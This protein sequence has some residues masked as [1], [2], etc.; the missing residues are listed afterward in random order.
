MT[1]FAKPRPKKRAI[2]MQATRLFSSFLTAALTCLLVLGTPNGHAEIRPDIGNGLALLDAQSNDANPFASMPTQ[3]PR[4]HAMAL[5]GESPLP[6]VPEK[7]AQ[8]FRQVDAGGSATCGILQGSRRLLCWGLNDMGQASPPIGKYR[9]IAMGEHHGCAITDKGRLRC[10]GLY[11]AYP[12][13]EQ[14]KGR[15]LSV[16]AG[17]DHTCAIRSNHTVACWGNNDNGELDAPK[18]KFRQLVARGN[19]SCGVTAKDGRL[20]CWGDKSFIGY[21]QKVQAPVKRVATGQLHACALGVDGLAKCWGN[22]NFGETQAPADQFVDIVA[23]DWHTCGLRADHTALCWGRDQYGQTQI[24][25][26]KYRMIAAGGMQTCGIL[27]GSRQMTCHGSFASNEVW[28][29]QD[30]DAQLRAS[31]AD[32]QVRPQLAFLSF[33]EGLSG[34]LVSGLVNTGKMVDQKMEKW[35]GRMVP[36][37]LGLL[38]TNMFLGWLLPKPPNYLPM[39]LNKLE[40]IQA[41]I[42][43]LQR[44]QEKLQKQLN[45]TNLTLLKSW[46][47]DR[48]DDYTAAYNLLDGQPYGETTGAHKAFAQVVNDQKEAL[49]K[50]IDGGK[51]VAAPSANLERFRSHYLAKL[52]SARTK[53]AN[54][55][56]GANGV[57]T[58]TFEACFQKGYA[59][60]KSANAG[61]A[62]QI[63]PFDDRMIYQHT[64]QILRGA[65]MMQEEMLWMEQEVEMQLAYQ[66]L[67]EPRTDGIAPVDFNPEEH[68]RGLCLRA[69]L[70]KDPANPEYNK[71]WE[72][73]AGICQENRDRIQDAYMRLVGQV[74]SAGGAY[75]DDQ[76]VLSLTSEQMGLPKVDGG[77][78][79]K[80]SNWLWVRNHVSDSGLLGKWLDYHQRD[81][82]SP[83]YWNRPQMFY[84]QYDAGLYIWNSGCLN[85][86]CTSK[87]ASYN[88]GV[89]HSNGQAWEDIKLFRI[90]R[91][92]EAEEAKRNPGKEDLLGRMSTLEDMV[93]PACKRDANGNCMTEK[94]SKGNTVNIEGPRLPLFTGI[95]RKPFWMLGKKFTYNARSRLDLPSNWVNPEETKDKFE[96]KCFVAKDINTNIDVKYDSGISDYKQYLYQGWYRPESKFGDSLWSYWGNDKAQSRLELSGMVCGMD[97]MAASLS[98]THTASDIPYVKVTDCYGSDVWSA[99]KWGDMR[100]YASFCSGYGFNYRPDLDKNYKYVSQLGWMVTK[101]RY[102]T[103]YG[104]NDYFVV[105]KYLDAYKPYTDGDLY[106]MPVVNIS[107]RKCKEK[108]VGQGERKRSRSG[109]AGQPEIPSICGA[110]LDKTIDQLIPRPEFPPVP[111]NIVRKPEY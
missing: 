95:D 5:M 40:D 4:S 78:D 39:I 34:L 54:S 57:Q 11:D 104:G 15:F 47:D 41:S 69:D 58:A 100:K 25:M 74:E 24:G 22:G 29:P 102:I 42:H 44:G 21:S 89:W 26:D 51:V 99:N 32:G 94:D 12:T 52:R 38:I 82:S 46:C 73:V 109:G 107:E 8:R 98:M 85:S 103:N 7:T 17:D 88:E 3:S 23:G 70:L 77:K 18:G 90:A 49:T 87:G 45:S 91:R 36:V 92:K 97:E 63:Y 59:E 33:Y 80:E 35:E 20:L 28:Y 81:D 48:L 83:F 106:H 13:V 79:Y 56:A 66:R 72:A 62:D 27:R 6:P 19:H 43:E 68:G 61:I 16:A 31:R 2:A 93:A 10:W 105:D 67:V 55:L 9:F 84:S 76:M 71:R 53:L 60:F 111:E 1:F 108:M 14:A 110:D 96:L 86:T 50:T 101:A 30:P 65:L 64:Y 37:Q 75:S